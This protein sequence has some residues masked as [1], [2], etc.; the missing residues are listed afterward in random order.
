MMRKKIAQQ[1]KCYWCGEPSESLDHVPPLNLFP[2]QYRKNLI[3]VGACKNHNQLF[4]KLDEYMSFLMAI[5]SNDGIGKAYFFNKFLS[6]AKRHQSYGLKCKLTD[7]Y[8][9]NDNGYF[10]Q[11][12]N[13]KEIDLYFEKIIRGII[14]HHY[15]TNVTGSVK[16]FS[17]RIINT[18]TNNDNL[19]ILIQTSNNLWTN[20]DAENK[21][22]FDYKYYY[23]IPEKRF[24]I[25]MTFYEL[26]E[27]IGVITS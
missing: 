19:K 9:I 4:S 17:N 1:N 23:S 11:I 6:M 16:Y 3:K 22:I 13:K 15:K 5:L 10:R 20:G 27:V 2:K 18:R 25:K 21:E 7:N 8:F 12:V 14:Y 24:F 26:H